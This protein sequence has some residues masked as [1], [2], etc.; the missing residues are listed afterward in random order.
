MSEQTIEQDNTKKN[1]LIHRIM[2]KLKQQAK[3]QNRR[4]NEA[5]TLFKLVF[6]SEDQLAE[7]AEKAKC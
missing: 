7:I 4:F 3:M 1:A 5:E 2:T 6:L